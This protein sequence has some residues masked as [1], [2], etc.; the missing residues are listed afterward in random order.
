MEKYLFTAVDE[1]VVVLEAKNDQKA[2]II[3]KGSEKVVIKAIG[4]KASEYPNYK[5][6]Y[7]AKAL[8]ADQVFRTGMKVM[9]EDFTVRAINYTE[10]PNDSGITVTIGG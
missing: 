7:E 6:S 4:P 5:G 1:G 9:Q 8:F 2:N 3:A 10:A